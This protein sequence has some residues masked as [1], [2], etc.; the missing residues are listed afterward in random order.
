MKCRALRSAIGIGD[1][2][3]LAYSRIAPQAPLY[4]NLHTS[5]RRSRQFSQLSTPSYHSPSPSPLRR[6]Y[7]HEHSVSSAQSHP[8]PF[9][10]FGRT[11]A[12]IPTLSV[13]D[14]SAPKVPRRTPKEAKESIFL[15]TLKG[16]HLVPMASSVLVD[17]SID[18]TIPAS[19]QINPIST[20]RTCVLPPYTLGIA[21]QTIG[22]EIVVTE[23]KE[24]SS[25]FGLVSAGDIIVGVDEFAFD[26][27]NVTLLLEIL[28]EVRGRAAEERDRESKRCG[29][30]C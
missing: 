26:A 12:K 2:T 14:L 6:G 5:R 23:V 22:D 10:P 29:A 18:Y 9:S 8:S 30:R 20:S 4:A 25:L 24:D 3:Y 21:F 11:S 19:S 17:E 7:D 27:D 13:A 28:R 16:L 15:K 1:D